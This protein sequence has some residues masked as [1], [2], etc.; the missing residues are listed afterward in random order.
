[1][2]CTVPASAPSRKAARRRHVHRSCEKETRVMESPTSP[3]VKTAGNT[4]PVTLVIV[5]PKGTPAQRTHRVTLGA[6][7]CSSF[8]S[9][10]LGF[11]RVL[12]GAHASH[13][14]SRTLK[15]R[16]GQFPLVHIEV[17]DNSVTALQFDICVR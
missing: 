16:P 12:F 4:S 8:R 2:Q 9:F 17:H 15:H 10:S 11:A 7:T 6:P 14:Q 3:A 5:S 1:M 13:R